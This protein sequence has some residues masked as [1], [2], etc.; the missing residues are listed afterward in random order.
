MSA[1][2]RFIRGKK[3]LLRPAEEAD[4]PLIHRWMNHPEVSALGASEAWR[5]YRERMAA[6]PVA[7]EPEGPG[8]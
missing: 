4:V 3:V 5:G 6:A 2:E 8:P 7:D 1:G